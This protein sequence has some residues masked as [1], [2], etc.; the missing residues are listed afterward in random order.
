MAQADRELGE[1]SAEIIW[2]KNRRLAN[3]GVTEEEMS[4]SHQA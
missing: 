1:N 3:N 2:S 4:V